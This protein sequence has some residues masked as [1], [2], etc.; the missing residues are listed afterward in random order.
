MTM[1]FLNPNAAVRVEHVGREAQPVIVIDGLL[2][3]PERWIATAKAARFRPIGPHYPGIRSPVPAA[4][5][6][7]LRN[8][9]ADLIETTFAVDPVPPLFECYFSIVTTPPHALTPIQ[10]LPHVDG[11]EPDRLAILVYLAGCEA[12]GTAFYRQRATGL[13][14]IDKSRFPTFD[15]ALHAGVVEH[16]LPGPAYIV[17]DTPLFEQVASIDAVP[18]RALI[19]RSHLLHCARIAPE[20]I[21]P[22]DPLTGRLTVNAF[23]FE[24][25]S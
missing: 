12:G 2:A 18:N 24:T 19:Y 23:L 1:R 3:E 6:L 8:E 25:T 17:G 16:G 14:T 9:L 11:V 13:E 7:A 20:T 4:P 10:R 15:A 5:A 22:D 21:L